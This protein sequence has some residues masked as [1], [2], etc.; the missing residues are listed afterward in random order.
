ME[1]REF[2]EIFGRCLSE[3][4]QS[5]GDAFFLRELDGLRAGEVQQRLGITPANLWK[6]LHRARSMLRQCLESRWFR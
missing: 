1:S 3:L 2:W 5:L 4:P 6:R